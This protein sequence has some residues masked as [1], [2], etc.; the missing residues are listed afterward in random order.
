MIS[1]TFKKYKV[2]QLIIASILFWIPVIVFSKLAGELTEN[3]PIGLDKL[4]LTWIHA[5]STPFL[6]GV[7]LFFTTIGNIEYILPVT[8]LLV[9]YLLYKKERL[10][11]L[12]VSFGVGGTALS[13]IILKIIFHRDRPNLWH[14]LITET[15]Y[16]FPS[17]HAMMSCALVLCIIII[18]WTTRLRWLSLIIGLPTVGLIGISRLYLG[19]HYPTDVIAGWSVSFV[20]IMIVFIIS[21]KLSKEFN[22]NNKHHKRFIKHEEGGRPYLIVLFRFASNSFILFLTASIISGSFAESSIVNRSSISRI[23]ERLCPSF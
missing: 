6:D 2:A 13:N 1:Q 9:A 20:W 22:K 10:N 14:S 17:G 12:I 4:I 21:K 18:L 8:I 15:G 11:A 23:S 16:S 7:F 19:V 3:E 5:Q